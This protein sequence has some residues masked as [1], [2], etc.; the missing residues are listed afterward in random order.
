MTTDADHRVDLAYVQKDARTGEFVSVN[1]YTFWQ[2]CRLLGLPVE[3]FDAARLGALPLTR[4]T[5]VCGGVG[6]VTGAL[7]RLGVTA[8]SVDGAPPA[9]GPFLGRRCWQTTMAAL[10]DSGD[11][12]PVFVKPLRATKLFPGHVRD[13][14]LRSAALTAHVD[15]DVAVFASEVVEFVAEYR[16]FVRSG[17]VVAAK[18]YAG[19]W[20]A[21]PL[22]FGVAD[23]AAAAFRG[24]PV[25]YAL[26]LG[27]ARDG[28]TL[29]VEVNDA[30]ALGCY[31]LDAVTYA[32]MLEDRWLELTAPP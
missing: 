17:A 2:G 24:A 27:L 7:A 12:A 18:H 10:R 15:D 9:L 32:R 1:A 31:G 14:S 13:G 30:F 23:A 8:P 21:G 5:L 3:P 22:D 28:R 4:R 20:R 16:C 6:A 25:A 29:V 19:D 26:D 11:K